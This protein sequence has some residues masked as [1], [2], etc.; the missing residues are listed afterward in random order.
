[1][2]VKGVLSNIY[3]YATYTLNKFRNILDAPGLE[4]WYRN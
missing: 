3:I 1:M 2:V 4:D